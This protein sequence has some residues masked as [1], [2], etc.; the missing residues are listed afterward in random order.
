MTNTMNMQVATMGTFG[1]F[2]PWHFG[3]SL[4][5]VQSVKQAMETAD[6]DWSV[7]QAQAYIRDENGCWIET[8][9]VVNYTSDNGM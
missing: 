4:N 6:L 9:A 1:R 3:T 5:G 7:N 8:P 2:E